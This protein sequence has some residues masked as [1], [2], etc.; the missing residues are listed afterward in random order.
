MPEQ[1]YVI[2]TTLSHFRLKYAIPRTEFDKLYSEPIDTKQLA[3]AI[4]AGSY[5]ELS[6]LHLGEIVQDVS[7][8]NQADAITIFDAEN[9]YLRDWSLEQKLKFLES[10]DENATS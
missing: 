3:E 7:V 5:K 6:Q 10:W 2:I 4:T 9:A 8:V 1:D